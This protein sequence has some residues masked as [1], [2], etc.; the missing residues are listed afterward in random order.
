MKTSGL[1]SIFPWAVGI[2]SVLVVLGVVNSW[3]IVILGAIILISLFAYFLHVNS[4]KS[5]SQDTADSI[6]YFGF[7]ITIITLA[8]SSIYHFG[9]KQSIENLGLVFSQ[10]GIGLI[11]TCFGLL[12]R[13]WIIAKL[14]VQNHISTVEEEEQARRLLISDLGTL[15][16]E[17]V[18][19]A[20]QLKELNQ[21]LHRQQKELHQQTV[22]DLKVLSQKT[23]ESTQQASLK[24]I[25]DIGQATTALQQLQKTFFVESLAT[26]KQTIIEVNDDLKKLSDK[27][28][29][30]ISTL[31]FTGVSQKTNT[32]ISHL[33]SSITQFSQQTAQATTHL[34]K[35]SEGLGEFSASISAYKSQISLV[36]SEI[37]AITPAM[38]N[39][40]KAL[41]TQ[42]ASSTKLLYQFDEQHKK[43]LH[44]YDKYQQACDQSIEE[45]T[46]AVDKVATALTEIA[47]DAARKL[48]SGT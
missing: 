14:N 2:V 16:L 27:T 11:A 4:L 41:E 43:Y 8:A 36:A 23:I 33:G 17:V 3:H 44:T 1:P 31:D 26:L 40:A 21:N 46:K 25:N 45:T 18:G 5:Y 20:E 38:A 12:L 28:Y 35:T 39:H 42:V 29:E 34:A 7:S 32:A 48:G 37:Q 13:L 22:N 6:Y 10:F 30:Q 15:R 19:F 47:N 24:A 9:N